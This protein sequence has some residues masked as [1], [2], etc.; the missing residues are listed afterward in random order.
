MIKASKMPLNLYPILVLGSMKTHG[1]VLFMSASI[2][3]AFLKNYSI[4]T[5][6]SHYITAVFVAE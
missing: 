2:C 6:T 4:K 1:H 5:G 3:G